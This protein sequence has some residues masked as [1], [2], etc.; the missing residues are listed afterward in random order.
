MCKAS[1]F[2]MTVTSSIAI[3]RLIVKIKSPATPQL[4]CISM[5]KHK[6]QKYIWLSGVA[7]NKKHIPRSLCRL[8]IVS[9]VLAGSVRSS[10]TKLQMAA[11]LR[12]WAPS[13]NPTH[14]RPNA[15][16]RTCNPSTPTMQ[17]EAETGVAWKLTSQ[18]GCS[19]PEIRNNVRWKK[20]TASQNLS[21]DLHHDTHVC[22]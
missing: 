5:V 11:S 19:Q 12:T 3:L 1:L 10:L 2:T 14:K 15:A 6:T 7:H 22:Q 16:A 8:T 13:L 21:S 20:R 17:W 18:P 4:E 9:A